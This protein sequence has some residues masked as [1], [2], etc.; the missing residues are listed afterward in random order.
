MIDKQFLIKEIYYTNICTEY[1]FLE[2]LDVTVYARVNL[3]EHICQRKIKQDS[4]SNFLSYHVQWC[5]IEK[6]LKI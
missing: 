6:L 4:L 2:I 5:E 3:P 1:P